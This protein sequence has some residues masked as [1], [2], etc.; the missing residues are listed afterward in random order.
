MPDESHIH[1]PCQEKLR[2]PFFSEIDCLHRF[3]FSVFVQ[4]FFLNT[5]KNQSE[6]DSHVVKDTHAG[7]VFNID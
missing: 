2:A 3:R 1:R 6:E 5:R 4:F 7:G